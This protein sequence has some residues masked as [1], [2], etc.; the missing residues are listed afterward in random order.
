[1]KKT[2]RSADGSWLEI[3]PGAD[4]AIIRRPRPEN[5]NTSDYAQG[6]DLFMRVTPGGERK[7]YIISWTAWGRD[8]KEA[9]RTM[10]EEQKN[11][12][13]LDQMKK[14]GKIGLDPDVTDKI[15]SLFPGLLKQK[16]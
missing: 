7:Y 15:E 10:T 11:Q 13:I 6:E 1:M 14:A 5:R 8:Y 2:I 4:T 3:D 12:F 9:Y 16:R